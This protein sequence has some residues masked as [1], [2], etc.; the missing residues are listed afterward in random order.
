[1]RSDSLLFILLLLATTGFAQTTVEPGEIPRHPALVRESDYTAIRVVSNN[2]TKEELLPLRAKAE[3]GDA[4]AQVTLGMAYQQGCPGAAH[5]PTEAL[6]WYRMAADQ[7]NSIAANQIAIFYDPAEHFGG[8]RGQDLPQAITWYRKAAEL[9]DVVGQYDLA[10]TLHQA[11]R[12]SEA[13]AAYRKATENGSSLAAVALVELYEQG[14]VIPD[15]NKHENWKAGIAYFQ[16]LADQ[17]NPGAEFVIAQGYREGWLGFHRDPHRAF[18][19]GMKAAEQGWPRAILFVGD[20]Y[21]KGIGVKKDKV[22]AVKWLQRAADQ[23]DPIGETYMAWIYENGDGAPQ[24]LVTAYMWFLVARNDGKMIK[25]NHH[26][27]ADQIADAEKRAHQF[28]VKRGTV[29][30]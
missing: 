12:D 13:I 15:E 11:G 24:D 30:Y 10:E 16:R 14:K 20:S 9:G 4:Q 26:L 28:V 6:K 25:F 2:L 1:M 17:G 7:G 19:F 23:S 29:F 8:L 18:D 21:F 5:D 22:E 3:A 27:A